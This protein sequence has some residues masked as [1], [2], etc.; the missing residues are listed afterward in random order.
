MGVYLRMYAFSFSLVGRVPTSSEYPHEVCWISAVLPVQELGDTVTQHAAGRKDYEVKST[1]VKR[2]LYI[3]LITRHATCAP[4]DRSSQ[5]RSTAFA[6]N[7]WEKK[8]IFVCWWML[9]LVQAL[10]ARLQ[11]CRNPHMDPSSAIYLEQQRKKKEAQAAERTRRQEEWKYSIF[12]SSMDLTECSVAFAVV[13][14]KLTSALLLKPFLSVIF[15][16][17]CLRKIW[18]CTMYHQ[19]RQK[20]AA[21][22]TQLFG[23][24]LW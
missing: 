20:E 7:N 13:W 4:I 10:H 8:Q 2:I 11:R 5:D 15:Q 3:S 12:G 22:Q 6:E 21:M 16:I 24:P 18:P 9:R 19:N 14:W 23:Q 17:D 1:T